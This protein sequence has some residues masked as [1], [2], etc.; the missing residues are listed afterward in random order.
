MLSVEKLNTRM[1]NTLIRF[2]QCKTNDHYFRVD[3]ELE[4]VFRSVPM[5]GKT[6]CSRLV[7]ILTN[8]RIRKYFGVWRMNGH[9]LN[10]SISVHPPFQ[11][12]F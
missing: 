2:Y 11:L 7:P 6:H 8:I 3:M 9:S 12:E 4:L 5:K 1:V 10:K